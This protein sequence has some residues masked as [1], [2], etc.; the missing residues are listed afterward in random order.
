M[1]YIKKLE[2]GSEMV[3]E[4]DTGAQGDKALRSV[5]YKLQGEI[6]QDI[7]KE[8]ETMR[9]QSAKAAKILETWDTTLTVKENHQKFE[10]AGLK[11][12]IYY[13]YALVKKNALVFKKVKGTAEPKVETAPESPVVEGGS[14]VVEQ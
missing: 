5:G 14:E 2:D 10:A 9:K 12:N 13:L 4:A 8:R 11:I 7:K 6:S 3:V 1:K